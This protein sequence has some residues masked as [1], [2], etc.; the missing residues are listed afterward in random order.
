MIFITGGKGFLGNYIVK[1]LKKHKYKVEAPSKKKFNIN[2]KTHLKKLKTKNKIIIHAAA[3]CGAIESNLNYENFLQTNFLGTQNLILEMIKK[4]INKLI[5]FSSLT[6]FGETSKG[7]S[8]KSRFNSR[9]IYSLTKVLCEKLIV[10]LCKM[11]NISYIILRPTLVV[12][13]NYK[14]PHALGDFVNKLSNGEKLEIYGTGNHKRDFIHPSDVAD[15]TVKSCRLL[16]KS[17]KFIGKSYN[18]NNNEII[19]IKELANLIKKNLKK[20]TITH[21]NKTN[22]TF[23][24][25]SKSRKATKELNWTPRFK[26]IDIINELK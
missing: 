18:L 12:G 19:K 3:L 21:V 17:K 25:F 4:K 8:E 2:S 22:Q 13:K 23:S 7:V 10:T 24:L 1:E 11:H 20:G 5:F 26:N 9:H 14:E 6:V 16:L 15:A